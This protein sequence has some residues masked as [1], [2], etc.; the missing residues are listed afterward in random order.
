[1]QS[2]ISVR[3]EAVAQ[4]V[5]NHDF[6]FALPAIV[7]SLWGLILGVAAYFLTGVGG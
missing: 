7:I 3:N 5:H 2:D 1:M 6:R 4:S